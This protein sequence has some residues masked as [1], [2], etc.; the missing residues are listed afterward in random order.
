MDLLDFVR[1]EGRDADTQ[2]CTDPR[3]PARWQTATVLL[4]RVLTSEVIAVPMT[5]EF[6]RAWLGT[7]EESDAR[8]HDVKWQ[9]R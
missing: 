8:G 1:Q 4:A 2:D 9:M 6:G 3:R 5:Q 7:M